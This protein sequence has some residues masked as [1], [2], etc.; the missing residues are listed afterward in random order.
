MCTYIGSE[1]EHARLHGSKPNVLIPCKSGCPDGF[2]TTLKHFDVEGWFCDECENNGNRQGNMAGSDQ[3]SWQRKT[4]NTL[5]GMD[6]G[7]QEG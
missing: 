5:I 3:A 4:L 7:G 2:F 1:I 6:G